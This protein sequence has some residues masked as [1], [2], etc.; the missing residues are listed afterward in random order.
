MEAD[1]GGKKNVA[2]GVRRRIVS[3]DPPPYVGG[4][5]SIEMKLAI[6]VGI[7]AVALAAGFLWLRK[8]RGQTCQV[9]M[10]MIYSAAVSYC[11]EQKLSPQEVLPTEKLAKYVK[12]S[13]IFCPLARVPY[14]A[15]SVLQG[16]RCPN[17]HQFEP[18]V[19][20]PLKTSSSSKGAGL[21]RAYGFTNLIEE[22]RP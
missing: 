17:G 14:P 9:H 18:G 10:N 5:G 11:L 22:P 15:F 3:Q 6:T 2:A 16:P 12:G 8:S 1:A 13:D 21:Y 4:H 19:P 20:R 7:L